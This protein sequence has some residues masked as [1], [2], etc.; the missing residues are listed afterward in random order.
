MSGLDKYYINVP[1]AGVSRTLTPQ[2][3]CD[4]ADV[5]EKRMNK[6]VETVTACLGVEIGSPR[7]AN[8]TDNSGFDSKGFAR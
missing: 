5:A 3:C 1:V 6:T 2:G 7:I 8:L 4:M